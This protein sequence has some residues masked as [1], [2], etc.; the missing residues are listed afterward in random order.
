MNNLENIQVKLHQF[1]RKFYINELIK[2]LLLFFTIG[3]LYFIFTLLIEHFLWLK[4]VARTLLFWLFIIVECTLLIF[5]ILIPIFKI[6]GFKN[7]ISEFEASDI[8]G[9]Y[10]PEVSDKLLNM[11]QLKQIQQNSELIEASIEQ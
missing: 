8:I 1:I 4:P 10:F 3:L 5:Y 9:K 2:G 11:L 7:G 6:G